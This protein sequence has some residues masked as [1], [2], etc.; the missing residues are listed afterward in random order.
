MQL[1][2]QRR[3]PCRLKRWAG[4]G[5][6]AA[7]TERCGGRFGYSPAGSRTRP[8]AVVGLMFRKEYV[9]RQIISRVSVTGNKRG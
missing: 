9:V 5:R 7:K 3:K 2:Q 1:V 8:E 4:I 6:A